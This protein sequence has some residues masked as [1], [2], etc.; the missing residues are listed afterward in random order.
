MDGYRYFLC[1]IFYSFAGWL[2]ESIYY[3]IRNKRPVN[4]GFLNG[5]LCP[6]YGIGAILN[7][8]LLGSIHNTMHLF[9]AG[10][11]V[12]CTLEYIVSWILEE[13]FHKRWWDY[14]A[15]PFNINGR[16]SLISSLAFGIFTVILIKFLHPAFRE[17][18]IHMHDN[19]VK[20]MC[21][22]SIL[23][24]GID[25]FVTLRNQQNFEKKLWF[26]D[27]TDRLFVEGDLELLQKPRKFVQNKIQIIQQPTYNIVK[28]FIDYLTKR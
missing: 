18:L 3:T 24:I 7:I 1:F 17:Y 4:T 26:V 16:V 25:L 10:I 11:I 8:L 23:C 28:K 27:Q 22:V 12:T 15:W 5:F 13:V 21:L 2:Y 19:T 14:S 20:L 9:I 6:I